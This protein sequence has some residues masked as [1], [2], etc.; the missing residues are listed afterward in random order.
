MEAFSI[1]VA[2]NSNSD[3]FKNCLEFWN[4]SVGFYMYEK[5]Q[6]EPLFAIITRRNNKDYLRLNVDR[7]SLRPQFDLQGTIL[8]SIIR[9]WSPTLSVEACTDGN[10][11]C[12]TSGPA[13]DIVQALGKMYNFSVAMELAESWG[14][15]PAAGEIH[16]L[17]LISPPIRFMPLEHV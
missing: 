10:L 9:P 14:E 13:P 7:K 4:H 11:D 16:V 15:K 5:D 17:V 2:I 8:T 6:Q 1:L 12:E 3:A